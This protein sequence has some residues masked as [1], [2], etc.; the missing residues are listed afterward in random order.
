MEWAAIQFF[1]PKLPFVSESLVEE[2][3][4]RKMQLITWTVN[5]REDMQR[6]AS[7]GVD[8]LISDDAKTLGETFPKPKATAAG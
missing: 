4:R 3:H 2:A 6:L 8:G 5:R 1:L 7:W